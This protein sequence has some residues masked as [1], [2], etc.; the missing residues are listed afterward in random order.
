MSITNQTFLTDTDLLIAI[1][2]ELIALQWI[3]LTSPA[4]TLNMQGQS[5]GDFCYL[6]ITIASR[7]NGQQALELRGSVDA[8]FIQLSP[9]ISADITNSST[10]RSLLDLRFE[11]NSSA[12]RLW[13]IGTT[14]SFV[15]AIK[16]GDNN[17]V[18]CW[19]FGFLD[20]LDYTRD[21][22]GWGLGPVHWGYGDTY[23]AKSWATNTDWF[24]LGSIFTANMQIDAFNA[25]N[26]YGL[27]VSRPKTM[28]LKPFINPYSQSAVWHKATTNS[29]SQVMGNPFVGTSLNQ[30]G[31]TKVFPYWLQE[32]EAI[33]KLNTDSVPYSTVFRG[34][35]KYIVTGFGYLPNGSIGTD[36]DGNQ[37]LVIGRGSTMAI[38]LG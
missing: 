4:N 30:T 13:L 3:K 14:D 26:A 32:I 6:N 7:P 11:P 21:P 5:Y 15:I 8:T 16:N 36:I 9:P 10:T 27:N 2:N 31:L 23:I 12:N 38:A 20:R 33:P 24:Y 28:P 1:E 29:A 19:W 25:N 34:F 35:I 37:Y 18:S 22:Y 17:N